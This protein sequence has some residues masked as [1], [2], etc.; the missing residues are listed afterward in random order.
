MAQNF[1]FQDTK[2][3]TFQDKEEE[4]ENK[5]KEKFIFDDSIKEV[6]IFGN[7]FDTKSG[8]YIPEKEKTFTFKE[9]K[10]EKTFTFKEPEKEKGI[11]DVSENP[12]ANYDERWFKDF[13]EIVVGGA[14]DITQSTIDWT[15]FLLPGDPLKLITSG[16]KY[17]LPDVDEP[18]SFYFWFC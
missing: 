6:T 11:I 9:P 18:E 14:R 16:N 7:T 8:E 3:F 1:I 12:Y 10:K 13:K 4:E 15:N 5:K 17:A 2:Q